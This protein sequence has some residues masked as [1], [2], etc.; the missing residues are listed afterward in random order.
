MVNDPESVYT[1]MENNA[2]LRFV[3][4]YFSI[5]YKILQTSCFN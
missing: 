1:S 2:G 3:S 5:Q 4:N